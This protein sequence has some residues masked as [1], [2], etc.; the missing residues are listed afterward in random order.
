[1]DRWLSA[2]QRALP[3][4]LMLLCTWVN[5]QVCAVPQNNGINVTTTGGQVVNGYYT[6]A[7]GTYTAGTQPTIAL[8]GARGASAWSVG[9]LALIIQ[10]QCVDL[11]RTES[12][13]YGDGVASRPA[14]GYLETGAGTCR[15][16]N[17]EYV[18]AGVGTSATS[19]VAG[20][21]L[22]NTYVQANPTSTT[23][24]RSFQIVRVPQ[25][26]NLTLGGTLNGLEW[27]GLNGGVLAL[28]VAKT[29]NLAG[30]TVDMSAQ[31]FRGGGG[32]QS[33]TDGNNPNR[34]R[35]G[36]SVSHASKGE[37]IA[38]TPRYLWRDGTPFDRSTIVGTFFDVS[39]QPYSGYPGTGT[40]ADFDFARGGPGNAG[41]G[42]QYFNGV[43]HN[44]GG[45]GGGNGGAG[46]RGAFG[47][48][49]AGWG[50][51][52]A[53]Y[54][55]I[56]T[57]TTQHLAAYGGGA[58]GGAGMARVVL[59]GGGGA[60]DENGNS[61]DTNGPLSHG[62]V[63]GA[64]GGG[65]VMIRAGVLTGA[66]TFDV[67]G[68]AANDQ[69]LNDAAGGG[70][71]GG[72]VVLVSPNWTSGAITVNAAGGRGGDSWLV[73]GSAHSG[74]GGG[75]GGVVVR[76]GAASADIAGGAN[77][78][79]NTADS[80]PGGAD[81]GAIS[82]NAGVDVLLSEASD[83]VS[84]SGYKCLPLTNLSLSKAA[85]TSTLV[86]GQTTNFVLT[87]GNSGPQQAT[88]ATVIDV[89]P[90]GLGTLSFVSASGSNAFTTLTAS[91]VNALT[92]FTGTV[93]IPANQTLTIV[94]QAVA[95]SNG[96]PLNAATVTAPLSASDLDLTDNT[97]TAS[98]VIG[99]S[100]D[101][102]ALKTANTPTLLVGGTT[103]FTLTFANAGPDAVT[104]ARLTDTLPVGMGTLTFVSVSVASGSTLTSRTVAG[105]VFSGTATL[106]AGSTLTVVL[107]AVGSAVG[108]VINSTIIAP[109]AGTADVNN[110]N[111]VGTAQVNI[112]PQADL[113]V[114]KSATPTSFVVGQTTQF[115]LTVRNLGP[116]TATAARLTD[117]LPAGLSGFTLLGIATSSAASTVTARTIVSTQ[118]VATLTLP[119]GGSIVFTLSAIASG[120]GEKVN[121][122]TVT[123]P[124]TVI[125][126][127]PSNNTAS[128]T[129]TIP[130]STN[131]S[132]TKTNAVG[133]VTS[134][135]TTVYTVTV[136]NLGPNAANG[137]VLVD[138]VVSGLSCSAVT[139]S[140]TAGAACP[141]SPNMAGLQGVGLT[142]PTF[143][144]TS[145]LVFVVTCA[146]TATG[147]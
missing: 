43:Y 9:D 93:T 99:P 47:W 84:N 91:A 49:S 92:T 11:N 36:D 111:N 85:T 133:T 27:N 6:P 66:G 18:P 128:A 48:R 61:G 13:S 65:V 106:P 3:V 58:F 37:G 17:Y 103:T 25:Y 19:F 64:S 8:S 117:A 89:R 143:P 104:G 121:I 77:G 75:G 30:Q 63:S 78:Q 21:T 41:G 141:A 107:R 101:L 76:T 62:R 95:A 68:G 135:G 94:L 82:G 98:V 87:V 55:N 110:S 80:P 142:I 145:Q 134:G 81:H 59:G 71:A 32:R 115:T 39:G 29:L 12:V 113:S 114:S 4:A 46:G 109:P 102:S 51:V 60:G 96:T 83:P 90:A 72:S 138:P 112:G 23:P 147:S 35:E 42:G 52:A 126:P 140:A 74:G 67:R 10:M 105:S 15:V 38:G 44:G 20:A 122:V 146:I 130:V 56:E 26:G 129:V 57:I 132:I 22:Q 24:R 1:M 53:D 73:G 14:Q 54:S 34:H 118:L 70:A 127:T 139:C 100:A 16:G 28:D 144:A 7:N 131:I 2:I 5:A 97:G 45:G 119:T 79:T 86:V 33:T 120:T 31:G 69:P 40:T 50:G 137:A 108:T 88:A 136:A 125:D 123:P 116:N 124:A